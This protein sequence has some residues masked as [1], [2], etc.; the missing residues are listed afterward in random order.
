MRAFVLVAFALVGCAVDHDV[1]SDAASSS[2]CGCLDA[3]SPDAS[4]PPL[5]TAPPGLDAFVPPPDAFT[6]RDAF[7]LDTALLPPDAGGPTRSGFVA[8]EQIQDTSPAAY[9]VAS[10]NG[11][12]PSALRR[13][14]YDPN[15]V[16]LDD[17]SPC[18]VLT[19]SAYADTDEAGEVSAAFGSTVL[20][21]PAPTPSGTT[22]SYS[23]YFAELTTGLIPEGTP[24]TLRATGATV[25]AFTGQVVMPPPIATMLPSVSQS[26]DYVVHWAPVAADQVWVGI[27]PV[28][29]AGGD[30][31]I[32][33]VAPASSGSITVPRAMIAR[34][35]AGA[36]VYPYAG[37]VNVA[38]VGAGDYFVELSAWQYVQSA[39]TVLP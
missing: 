17:I 26:A 1:S 6:P 28:S 16:V 22:P 25:P 5:D 37:A 36:S 12:S 39:G 34:L 29:T 23:L 10:F 38:Y 30:A 8:V 19:C 27:D 2:E 4:S 13:H 3:S 15:C 31:Y 14:V 21:A 20:S 11:V 24:L 33:C 32:E 35:T 7:A 18:L 9:L